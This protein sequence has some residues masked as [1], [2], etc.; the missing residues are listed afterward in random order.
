MMIR[1]LMGLAIAAVAAPG[2]SSYTAYSSQRNDRLV[3][4]QT[5]A[6]KRTV[7]VFLPGERPSYPY[8]KVEAHQLKLRGNQPLSE[9]YKYVQVYGQEKGLDFVWVTQS[10]PRAEL[11]PNTTVLDA[12]LYLSSKE[13]RRNPQND[14]DNPEYVSRQYQYITLIGGIKPENIPALQDLVVSDSLFLYANG[15]WIHLGQRLRDGSP[16]PVRQLNNMGQY[17][18]QRQ[19]LLYDFY[20][21]A[22]ETGRW[23]YTYDADGQVKRRISTGNFSKTVVIVSK[24]L[25]GQQRIVEL[26][27]RDNDGNNTNKYKLTLTYDDM[28]RITLIQGTSRNGEALEEQW[29]YDNNGRLVL[30]EARIQQQS[31]WIPA[32]RIVP[33]YAKMEQVQITQP[34]A[35]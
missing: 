2:C 13:Y 33:E 27:V 15:N 14:V 28:A 23:R 30:R 26:Q 4:F 22:E 17:N 3:L 31:A 6:H 34:P 11:E 18:A 35:P 21:L 12:I 5:P 1:L 9:I 16:N 7:D 25:D 10:D 24:T 8:V 19:I 32:Y 29:Q 20:H